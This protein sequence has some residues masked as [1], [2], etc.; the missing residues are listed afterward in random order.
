MRKIVLILIF[1]VLLGCISEED[2]IKTPE[3]TETP[4]ITETPKEETSITWVYDVEQAKEI[5]KNG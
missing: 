5:A 1:S 4:V 2:T 3:P